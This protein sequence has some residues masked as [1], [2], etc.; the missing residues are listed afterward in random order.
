MLHIDTGMARLGLTTREFERLAAE[1]QGST[2]WR[3]LISHLACADEPGHP[4]NEIQRARFLSALRQL[5]DPPASLAASSGIFLG[6]GYHFDFVRP[7]AALYGVNPQPGTPNPMR[8]VVR[9]K[10]RILQ[11]REVDLKVLYVVGPR[12]LIDARR[13]GLL[14]TEE[15]RPQDIDTDVMQE[16]CQLTLSVPSDGFSYAGLRL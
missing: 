1:Q 3:A 12:H 9:L 8:Q 14:Q 5:G 2:R 16:R 15:A 10:G 13:G 4:L 11:V 6:R 7:G